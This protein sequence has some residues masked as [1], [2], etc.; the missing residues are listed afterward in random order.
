MDNITTVWELLGWLAG[1][2]SVILVAWAISWGCEGWDKWDNLPGKLKGL[3]IV[4][5]SAVLGIISTWL[6]TQPEFLD[7]VAPYI[8]TLI[9]IVIAWLATQ[10]A[11]KNDIDRYL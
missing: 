2:G 5:V 10:V 3:I 8:A 7:I 4:L 9:S 6:Q 11:H 1:P